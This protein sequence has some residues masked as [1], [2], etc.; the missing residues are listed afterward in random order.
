MAASALAFACLPNRSLSDTISK[1][2]Y[3][4]VVASGTRLKISSGPKSA[5]NKGL[6]NFGFGFLAASV[7]SL[8]PLDA[9]AT[10]VEYYATV[11]EP[12][13]ELNFVR[14]G[15]GYCDVTVGSGEEAPRAEL[16]NVNLILDC[17]NF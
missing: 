1:S 17:A 3:C 4:S 14:S 15:L 6:L 5:P 9:D 13:C 11:G 7:L 16:I 8:T 2:S 12:S 10:R